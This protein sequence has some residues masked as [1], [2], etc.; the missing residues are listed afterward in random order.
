MESKDIISILLSLLAVIVSIESLRR[1]NNL[2][3]KIAEKQ[4]STKFFEELYFEYIITKL[5]KSILEVKE[6]SS[7]NLAIKS[8]K[9]Q[10][11]IIEILMQSQFY[12]YFDEKFYNTIRQTL[13]NVEEILTK[14]QEP[15]ID[16]NNIFDLRRD[17]ANGLNNFYD[18]L[19]NY[20]TKF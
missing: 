5:P 7:T 6:C 11:I 10:E 8:E 15:V 14:L 3:K 16:S 4:L 9:A 17:L 19:K 20:Y 12:K 2:T 1:T 13:I 18:D